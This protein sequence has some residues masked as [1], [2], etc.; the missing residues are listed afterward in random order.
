MRLRHTY[1]RVLLCFF[2][3]SLI[4]ICLWLMHVSPALDL[5]FPA[6]GGD[7]VR[8]PA[9]QEQSMTM[10]PRDRASTVAIRVKGDISGSATLQI[11][12]LNTVLSLPYDLDK[13]L[14]F[15]WYGT[16]P[17]TVRYLPTGN[18]SGSLLIQFKFYPRSLLSLNRPS[19]NG[20]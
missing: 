20:V 11:V 3:A 13:K 1:K 18:V 9:G 4:L 15:D 19:E 16:T 6:L 8:L 7:T 2:P 14:L 17:I 5:C 12:S 10:S